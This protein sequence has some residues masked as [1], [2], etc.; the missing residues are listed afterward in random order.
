MDDYYR[1]L[2][3]PR[4][5]TAVEVKTAFQTKMKALE[6]SP[7]HGEHRKVQEKVLQQAFLT[8]LDPARR[9]KYDKQVDAASRPAVVLQV[10][11][12]KR[13]SVAAIAAGALLLVAVVAGGWYLSHPYAVK[14]E[15]ERKHDEE[16]E[17]A[18]RAKMEAQAQRS[19]NPKATDRAA[20]GAKE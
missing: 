3:V 14:R 17:R 10:E 9:G 19:K 18:F 7:E 20:K 12:P 1:L 15:A 6:A 13:V 5:A 4:N 2:G 16:I 8:L 11:E